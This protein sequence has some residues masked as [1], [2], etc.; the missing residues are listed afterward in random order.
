MTIKWKEFTCDSCDYTFAIEEEILEKKSPSQCPFCS[1]TDIHAD[2]AIEVHE[3]D[4]E[5]TDNVAFD[6]N[7]Q[8]KRGDIYVNIKGGKA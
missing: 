4:S 8:V 7:V 1:S 2:K 5:T 6:D 3:Y